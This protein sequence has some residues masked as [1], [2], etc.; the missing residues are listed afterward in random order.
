MTQED[1]GADE[2]STSMS[3]PEARLFAGTVSDGFSPAWT[4]R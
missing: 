2:L 4:D 1:A 3:L